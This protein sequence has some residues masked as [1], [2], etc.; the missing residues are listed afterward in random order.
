[1]I[2]LICGNLK[3]KFMETEQNCSYQGKWEASVSEEASGW[4]VSSGDLTRSTV[5][6]VKTLYDVLESC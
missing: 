5:I 2:S 6:M 4:K 3:S 1:M